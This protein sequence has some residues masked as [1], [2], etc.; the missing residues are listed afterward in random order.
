MLCNMQSPTAPTALQRVSLTVTPYQPLVE[1]ARGVYNHFMVCV[2]IQPV[3]A[4]VPPEHDSY[5]G[6]PCS[7]PSKLNA[8]CAMAP[9]LRSF[10]T[11]YSFGCLRLLSM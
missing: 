5:N 7:Y 3:R 8:V 9:L 6:Q 1:K 2:Y 10:A 11:Q 4:R